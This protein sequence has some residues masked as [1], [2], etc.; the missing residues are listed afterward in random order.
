MVKH[1]VVVIVLLA[2]CGRPV[3]PRNP[4]S[5]P[6]PSIV[7]EP[8]KPVIDPVV[9]PIE[10]APAIDPIAKDRERNFWLWASDGRFEESKSPC[11]NV[12][13]RPNPARAAIYDFIGTGTSKAAI[14][15]YVRIKDDK[16]DLVRERMTTTP[17]KRYVDPNGIPISI[18][19][20]GVRTWIVTLYV[21]PTTEP[22]V[23]LASPTFVSVTLVIE[24]NDKR[25]GKPV[26][27]ERWIG[28]VS[29]D[30]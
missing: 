19:Y 13:K 21:P 23:V 8:A 5:M 11:S 9:E 6:P 17:A 10:P 24:A 3:A 30:E 25:E 12:P 18:W 28:A 20:Q 22:E 16:L 15:S 1:L 29:P 27:L 2:A 14:V 7:V 26:C 4:T